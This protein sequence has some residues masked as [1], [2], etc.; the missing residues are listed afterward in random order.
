MIIRLRGVGLDLTSPF[1]IYWGEKNTSINPIHNIFKFII[2]NYPLESEK[3][4]PSKSLINL[5]KI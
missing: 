5:K 3:F 2:D 4:L 1:D